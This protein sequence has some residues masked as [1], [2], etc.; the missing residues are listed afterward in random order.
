MSD[1]SS[2]SR[3][4]LGDQVA[5]NPGL[6]EDGPINFVY[7]SIGRGALLRVALAEPIKLSH[8]R[9]GS[10]LSGVLLRP[11]YAQEREAIPAGS[12]VQLV[13]EKIEREKQA[14]NRVSGSLSRLWNTSPRKRRVY[15]VWFRSATL[16]S[17]DG[18]VTPV[19][20]SCGRIGK[21]IQV[22]AK[23]EGIT[24]T[25]EPPS[26][27][28]QDTTTSTE[29]VLQS[30]ASERLW[31]GRR[32]LV[33]VLQLE[34]EITL[35]LPVRPPAL[36]NS[37]KQL[38]IVAS[39]RARLS[40]LTPL[41][42]SK[43]REGDWFQARLVEPLRWEGQLISE[44]SLFEGRITRRLPP[45][46]L[47]RPGSLY[48]NFE[49]IIPPEGPP[50]AISSSIVGVEADRGVSLKM[51]S[52]GMLRGRNPGV[53]A[54]AVEVGLSYLLGKLIDDLLEEG[55]KAIAAGTAS[56]TA[57][58]I[59]RY[60]GMGTGLCLF[61]QRRGANVTLEKYTELEVTFRHRAVMGR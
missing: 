20:V 44:G 39:S 30:Q 34:K 19:T 48:L 37:G 11:L 10:S 42:A 40:L 23:P 21:F 43:N 6:P 18:C 29:P 36:S 25:P 35:R 45:R 24:F 15:S 4:G 41:S 50:I 33:L 28:A 7:S 58:A 8:W 31:S 27:T 2:S 54:F 55:I 13:V 14:K 3:L 22:R 1:L 16:T 32:R 49:R 53:G 12:Q 61:L 9:P 26:E 46:R 47:S 51:D 5:P 56:G 38:I 17:P 52:E 57:A 60:F 59:G